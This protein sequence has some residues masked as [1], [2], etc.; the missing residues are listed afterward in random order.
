MTRIEPTTIS[1]LP[2]TPYIQA[3]I[4][5]LAA[6]GCAPDRA[7]LYR[8]AEPGQ[9]A[10]PGEGLL[11]AVL[12]WHPAPRH[13]PHGQRLRWTNRT[14]WQPIRPGSALPPHG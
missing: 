9:T 11:V 6:G 12:E 7:R 5:Q 13:H 10:G 8:A 2:H 4:E 14:G 3:V 1:P